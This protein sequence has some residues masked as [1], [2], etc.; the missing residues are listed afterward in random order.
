VQLPGSEVY[1]ALERGVVDASDW[2]TLSMNEDLGYHKLA[3]YPTYPGFHSMPSGDISVNLKRWEALSAGMKAIIEAATHEYAR[4]MIQENYLADQKVAVEASKRGFEPIDLSPAERQKF[5]EVARGVWKNYASRSP[6][7][8]KVYDSQV[9]F[10][11]RL[12]LLK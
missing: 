7:A 8:Q 4:E 11:Q 5:R 3:R 10:L 1:T 12:G 9:A 2:G 6:L